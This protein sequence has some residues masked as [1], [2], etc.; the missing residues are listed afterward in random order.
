MIPHTDGRGSRRHYSLGSIEMGGKNVAKRKLADNVE[1]T[2]AVFGT[3]VFMGLG[4][5]AQG[6][7]KSS[8]PARG[9]SSSSQSSSSLLDFQIDRTGSSGQQGD[10]EKKKKDIPPSM[11]AVWHDDDD[12][13]VEI[14]LNQTDRLK[15]LKKAEK[16]IISG[17]ELSQTLNERW[18]NDFYLC[19]SLFIAHRITSCHLRSSQHDDK[20][21][22][23]FSK[24]T[25][26][27]EL[28]IYRQIT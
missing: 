6:H 1:L 21:H 28:L 10:A 26:A 4:K 19:L 8:K 24:Q 16:N 20:F 2:R 12:D 23:I 15:K 5:S 17:T 3:D 14:D 25:S 11:D 22:T 27:Y 13:K 18:M 9:S 7:G